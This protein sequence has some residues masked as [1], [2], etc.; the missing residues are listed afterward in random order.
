M[1]SRLPVLLIFSCFAT[2]VF[3]VEISKDECVKMI[4][5]SPAQ[6]CGCIIFSGVFEKIE[7]NCTELCQ[8]TEN[9]SEQANCCENRCIIQNA[10]VDDQINK[11]ML[12]EY[13]V[14]QGNTSNL[15]K[16]THCEHFSEITVLR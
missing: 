9:S 7:E 3:A 4:L 6:E 13:L 12:A 5:E 10:M 8:K 11:E 2:L 15:Q 14:P 16:I 1:W